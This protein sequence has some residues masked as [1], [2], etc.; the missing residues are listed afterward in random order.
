MPVMGWDE[1]KL[2]F[3][4]LQLVGTVCDQFN[5]T[6]QTPNLTFS[7]LIRSYQDTT[8]PFRE[9]GV[10]NAGLAMV[11]RIS[12]PSANDSSFPGA[13]RKGPKIVS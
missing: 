4:V 10:C 7:H 2:A 6:N 13:W 8:L 1:H 12:E 11:R 9:R 5:K 3:V